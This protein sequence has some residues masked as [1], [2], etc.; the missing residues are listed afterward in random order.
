MSL[1]IP[2]TRPLA[3]LMTPLIAACLSSLFARDSHNVEYYSTQIGEQ[4][5]I[6]ESDG[7]VIT[8]NTDSRI[9]LRHD[10]PNLY[11]EILRGEVHFDI[12]TH[13]HGRLVVSAA[14]LDVVDTGTAFDVRLTDQGVR[15]TVK[16][17]TVALSLDHSHLQLNENQQALVDT[18]PTHLA[19]RARNIPPREV[20]RQL[21]WLQGYLD[22]QC[23]TLASAARSLRLYSG[24][25]PRRVAPHAR[26]QSWEARKSSPHHR[27]HA[28]L[29]ENT[30]NS[31]LPPVRFLDILP[32]D[33]K[34]TVT[35]PVAV[36]LL[37]KKRRSP[38]WQ[39]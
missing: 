12:G 36:P 10:G 34:Q 39:P 30:K 35:H 18:R 2:L 17:G 4:H 23:E 16:E 7:S 5:P 19:I 32:H 28:F 24:I 38:Q 1:P 9:V 21:S 26:P 14:G 6:R 11:V 20:E 25:E 29:H 8:L 3:A 22:F 31:P 13:Y 15:V 33:S 27:H 37:C